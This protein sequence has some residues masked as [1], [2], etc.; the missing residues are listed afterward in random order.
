MWKDIPCTCSKSIFYTRKSFWAFGN[1][2]LDHDGWLFSEGCLRLVYV[3]WA[4]STVETRNLFYG[5]SHSEGSIHYC[6]DHLGVSMFEHAELRCLR[7]NGFPNHAWKFVFKHVK[8]KQNTQGA[9]RAHSSV[10]CC[11]FLVISFLVSHVSTV[12]LVFLVS[13]VF[14]IVFLFPVFLL[15]FVL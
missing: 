13:L 6:H 9:H 11:F 7:C 4:C 1:P 5:G 12:F 15:L 14:L 3:F 2:T 10:H 8:T